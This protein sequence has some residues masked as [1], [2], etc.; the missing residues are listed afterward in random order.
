LSRETF[1]GARNASMSFTRVHVA[2]RPDLLTSQPPSATQSR[3][4]P[5]RAPRPGVAPEPR[6]DPHWGSGSPQRDSAG[7]TSTLATPA[8]HG[9]GLAVARATGS[10]RGRCRKPLL[11]RPLSKRPC[12][13]Q[14]PD[15]SHFAT[16]ARTGHIYRA[17]S[18]R[19]HCTDNCRQTAT[20]YSGQYTSWRP[21]SSHE[22]SVWTRWSAS[23][24]ANA[25]T[26]NVE[27]A[28]LDVTNVELLATYTFPTPCTARLPSTTPSAGIAD[29]RVVPI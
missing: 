13:D 3:R 25:T 5:S 11:S 21:A 18:A 7:S 12:L 20:G 1:S 4:T 10:P 19:C 2:T 16:L 29:I 23:R 22:R 28:W 24:S 9:N 15:R 17:A 27:F 14:P 6:Q 26:M 8:L